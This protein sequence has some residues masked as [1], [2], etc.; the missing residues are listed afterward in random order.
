MKKNICLY[1]FSF[2]TGIFFLTCEQQCPEKSE[3]SPN[4]FEEKQLT[5]KAVTYQKAL[6]IDGELFQTLH[7]FIN[8]SLCE[9]HLDPEQAYYTGF[10]FSYTPYQQKNQKRS[11]RYPHAHNVLFPRK[12]LQTYW[13]D[14]LLGARVCLA[15]K[16]FFI[17]IATGLKVP[18][19]T[20]KREVT[21]PLIL[22]GFGEALNSVKCFFRWGLFY[23]NSSWFFLKFQ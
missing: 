18:L 16:A 19:Y 10:Y 5:S 14:P 23:K 1:N 15:N 7:G 13:F 11:M 8:W 4:I 3:E 12:N 17:E 20:N 21:Y 22:S 2:F 6:F 9:N